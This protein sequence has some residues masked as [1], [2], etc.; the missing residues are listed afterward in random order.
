MPIPIKKSIF[1]LETLPKIQTF[2]TIAKEKVD[3]RYP[4]IPPYAYA[5]IHWDKNNKEL[6]YEVEEP[7]LA[8]EE[9][10]VL[11]LLEE[12][13]KEL[14][15]ISYISVEKGETLIEYLEK[16]IKVLLDELRIEITDSSYLKIMYYVYRDFV[17][18]GKIEPLLTDYFI[19]DIECNGSNFPLY[20]IH[21]KYRNMRT[22][23]IYES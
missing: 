23:I 7:Q 4:L 8:P 18:L 15:N 3:F 2:P 16:N 19:E 12:G 11:T 22:N 6:I 9:K 5:H 1:E 13:I 14:I 20:I 17:G 10:K 21:R